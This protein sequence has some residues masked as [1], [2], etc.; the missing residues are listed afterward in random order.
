MSRFTS[1]Y[2]AGYVAAVLLLGHALV[3][4]YWAAGGTAGLGL[5][6][7]GMQELAAERNTPF[8]LLVWAVALLKTGLAVVTLGLVRGWSFPV[9]RWMPMLAVWSAGIGLSLYAVFQIA[10][11][12]I[13]GL[14]QH[15][16]EDLP[17]GFWPYLLL[18]AP[19]WLAIGVTLILTAWW[20][21][22][23]RKPATA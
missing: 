13:G 8:V 12:S 21:T 1:P 23:Q 4:Y 17:V 14:I 15:G 2:Q 19:L 10:A 7:E 22:G 9:P 18:W 16:G 5:L 20:A 6:V 3:S 11:L